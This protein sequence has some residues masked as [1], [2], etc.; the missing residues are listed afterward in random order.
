MGPKVKMHKLRWDKAQILRDALQSSG[1]W[2]WLE[3]PG[4]ELGGAALGAGGQLCF[5]SL[6]LQVQFSSAQSLSCVWLFATPWTA[7]HQASLSIS[8]FWSLPKLM[9]I[10]SVMPSIHLILCRPLLLLPSVFPGIRVFSNES[11]LRIRWPK[12]WGLA[13]KQMLNIISSFWLRVCVWKGKSSL[14]LSW[15]AKAGADVDLS[16]KWSSVKQTVEEQGIP[17][18]KRRIVHRK[19][20]TKVPEPLTGPCKLKLYWQGLPWK[21]SG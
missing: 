6:W 10:E 12:Y 3:F 9:S 4:L 1:G 16:F 8:N 19:I 5:Y 2:Y 21:S 13:A 15:L 14:N 20:N 7:A 18:V 17:A 11:A